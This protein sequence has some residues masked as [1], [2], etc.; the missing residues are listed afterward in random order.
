[1]TVDSSVVRR[2]HALDQRVS[3]LEAENVQLRGQ[4]AEP[5]GRSNVQPKPVSRR[6]LLAA[7]S[8]AAAGLVVGSGTP[9]LA[10]N[11]DSLVLGESNTSSADTVLEV[12]G[13]VT[14]LRANT[15]DP[16][17]V[18]LSGTAN[19]ATG[20]SK[21]VQGTSTSTGGFGVFGRA[22]AT[23]GET[24]GVYGEANSPDGVGVRGSAATGSGA[25][26]GV[27]GETFS[28]VGSGVYGWARAG[29]GAG[30]GIHGRAD[31]SGGFAV[32]AEGRLKATGRSYLGTPGTAP[33]DSDLA[34]GSISFYT[35][36]SPTRLR[37][38]VRLPNGVLRTGTIPLS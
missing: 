9:A 15:Y 20:A 26:Q 12:S 33:A 8:G 27:L 18:G 13:G 29:S 23:S 34:P 28:P 17:A 35:A 16:S 7:A 19:S 11:G 37:V 38:R 10:A 14:G 32:F 31:A 5:S 25:A 22:F 36:S 24:R 3:A 6:S 30:H 4:L 2:L 21:G 1:M